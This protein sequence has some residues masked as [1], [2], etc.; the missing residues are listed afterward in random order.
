MPKFSKSDKEIEI[1]K[2]SGKICALA[3]KK[4]LEDVKPGVKCSELDKIAEQ[5]LKKHSA[6]P[7]FKTVE[8]Y[9]YTICT[10]VNQQV[11]H[12]IPSNRVLEEGDIVGIDIGAL[13]KGFHSD[14]AITVPVGKIGQET[15]KFLDVGRATLDEAINKAVVGNTIGDISATIQNR[16]EGNGYSVVKNLTGHGVGREL[17]EEPM[18]P[19]FGKK[20]TGPRLVENMTIA[21]E[22]IY[23]KGSGEVVLEK[24][25]W[26]ISSKDRSIGGLFEKTIAIG[27]N[28]PIVL[29]P[30]F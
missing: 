26:T 14:L 18:V 24:D 30:Y 16:I 8:D 22:V 17:H 7:S 1:M 20:G 23:T 6:E 11:V 5:E 25:N 4:V 13:Y 15:K 10:T 27:R 3:L 2:K 12:G 9:Q 29:T 19:G 21:I 28:G